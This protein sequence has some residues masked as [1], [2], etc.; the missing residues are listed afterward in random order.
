MNKRILTAI[1]ILFSICLTGISFA[2]IEEDIKSNEE[3]RYV[4]KDGQIYKFDRKTGKLN[5]MQIDNKNNPCAVSRP[6]IK[7][8]ENKMLE[9]M[10][11]SKILPPASSFR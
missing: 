10:H 6:D 3:N 9:N 8:I 5:I 11:P 4:C 2:K 7:Y 1:F